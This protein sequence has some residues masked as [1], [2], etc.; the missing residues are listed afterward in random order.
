M[1]DALSTLTGLQTVPGLTPTAA[2]PKISFPPAP[3]LEQLP[4]IDVG[5]EIKKE[6]EFLAPYREKAEKATAEASRFAGEEA[7]AKSKAQMMELE[8]VQ[9]AGEQYR[10]TLHS[11]EIENIN[12]QIK[13]LEKRQQQEF[14]PTQANAA[15]LGAI[16][17][18]LGVV[19]FAVGRGAKGNAYGAMSAMSGM[20]NGYQQG[21]M[22]LYKQ[23][24]DKFEENLKAIKATVDSLSKDLDRR[25]KEASTNYDLAV[26]GAKVDAAKYGADFLSANIDRVGLPAAAEMARQAAQDA[27][28]LYDKANKLKQDTEVSNANIRNKQAELQWQKQTE[29]A[30]LEIQQRQ[31][32][33]TLAGTQFKDV[34][35]QQYALVSHF[36]MPPTDVM[37]L[38]PKEV[39]AVS[40]QLESATLTKELAD[41]I[42]K[43]PYAA[44]VVG[45]FLSSIDK[46]LPSG[47]STEDSSVGVR[48]LQNAADQLTDPSLREDQIATARRIAKMGVDVINARALAAS[49]GSRVLV[50]E[51][52]MQKGV[53][54]LEGMSAKSAGVV[55]D[56]LAASDIN[57]ISRYGV[58]PEYIQ[59][60]KSHLGLG[61]TKSK[62][63]A[64]TSPEPAEAGQ[65]RTIVKDGVKAI[66]TVE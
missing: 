60:Y 46:Y 51:L 53:I 62:P 64:G 44:G 14:I 34:R 56:G 55:Y 63:S 31:H 54:G 3:K 40:G 25:L 22:D 42:R 18:L 5:Q 2:A 8:G 29:L 47:Y 26:Q 13:D 4:A 6:Q 48:L 41:E 11:P 50:S 66:V 12:N 32:A 16:F 1:P 59:S 61:E 24:K 52:N 43:H 49:G 28:G 21:R 7:L 37:R 30:K 10:E 20:L 65:S 19:G 36:G 27:Q 39:A 33:E 57:K 9:K 38:G 17:S 45:K 23:E 35:G 15:D 58:S